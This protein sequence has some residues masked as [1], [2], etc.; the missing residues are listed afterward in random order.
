MLEY[1]H[2]AATL[3]N[4]ALSSSL[5]G[6]YVLPTCLLDEAKAAVTGFGTTY[7]SSDVSRVLGQLHFKDVLDKVNNPEKPKMFFTSGAF[8]LAELYFSPALFDQQTHFGLIYPTLNLI[9]GKD[10]W[11]SDGKP[12]VGFICVAGFEALYWWNNQDESSDHQQVH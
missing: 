3:A 1:L 2:R 4:L 12:V 5:F 11:Y 7:L 6:C 10:A 8:G 9:Y